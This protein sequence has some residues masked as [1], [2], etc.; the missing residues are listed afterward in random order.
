[1][2]EDKNKMSEMKS[3]WDEGVWV[4][5]RGAEKE[6][7]RTRGEGEVESALDLCGLCQG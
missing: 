5:K 3:I 2:S 1:M 4:R 7:W 6:I